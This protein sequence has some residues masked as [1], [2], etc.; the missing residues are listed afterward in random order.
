LSRFTNI[1]ITSE[2]TSTNNTTSDNI[3]T[4]LDNLTNENGLEFTQMMMDIFIER[5]PKDINDIKIALT[6]N[7]SDLLKSKAHLL[8]GSLG[9]LNFNIG[10][11]LSREI[12]IDI[13]NNNFTEAKKKSEIFIIYLQK[14]L[15]EIIIYCKTVVFKNK[16]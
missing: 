2:T 8:S 3:T 16:K 7:D 12:E 6:Q 11:K 5:I 15:S 1:S 9:S 13:Q 10:L 4:I 14:T